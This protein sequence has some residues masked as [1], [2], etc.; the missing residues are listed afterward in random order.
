[1]IFHFVPVVFVDTCQVYDL[2]IVGTEGIDE[3]APW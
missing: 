3:K 2:C 1:M